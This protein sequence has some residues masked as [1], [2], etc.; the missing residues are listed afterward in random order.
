[1]VGRLICQ[2]K[3]FISFGDSFWLVEIVDICAGWRLLFP[4]WGYVKWGAVWRF[5]R[6]TVC[7]DL[8]S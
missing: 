3:G 6:S 7:G 4:T 1:M 8:L 5:K 2:C